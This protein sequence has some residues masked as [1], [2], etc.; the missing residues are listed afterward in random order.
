MELRW[1]FYCLTVDMS[2]SF[3]NR[4]FVTLVITRRRRSVMVYLK[5]ILLFGMFRSCSCM[6]I[7]FDNDSCKSDLNRE[8]LFVWCNRYCFSLKIIVLFDL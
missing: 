6:L 3:F 1:L 5:R 7:Y 4:K 8:G 2:V